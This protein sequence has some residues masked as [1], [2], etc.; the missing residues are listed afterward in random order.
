MSPHLLSPARPE[1]VAF[2][3]IGTT[4]SLEP[5][6]ERLTALGLAPGA[7]ETWFASGL[8]D[9]FALAASDGFEPFRTVLDGALEQV[10]AQSGVELRCSRA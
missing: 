7:L 4:F 6:R 2:D 9:A 3:M 10:L 1:V 8:R 5:L